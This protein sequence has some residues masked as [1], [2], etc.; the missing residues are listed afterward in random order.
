MM[1]NGA[2]GIDFEILRASC[3]R[4][5]LPENDFGGRGSADV[6][7]AHEQDSV[8]CTDWHGWSAQIGRNP[9]PD[10]PKSRAFPELAGNGWEKSRVAEKT[11]QPLGDR[12]VLTA[13]LITL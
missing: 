7:K 4:S 6:A 1:P 8:G 9:A 12:V 5:L 13:Q 2:C 10:N 3:I 11:A